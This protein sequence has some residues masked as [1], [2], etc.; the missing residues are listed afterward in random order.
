MPI[1]PADLHSDISA[2]L[3]TACDDGWLLGGSA[4]VWRT[5]KFGPWPDRDDRSRETWVINL[6][7]INQKRN[8]KRSKDLPH[9]ERFDGAWFDFAITTIAD[10]KTPIRLHSYSFEIRF[11]RWP[12]QPPDEQRPHFLRFDLNSPKHD[13]TEIGERCHMHIGSDLFSIPSPW[14]SPIEILDE[15]VYGLRPS[16]IPP[17]G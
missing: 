11:P 3:A 16:N 15:F 6:G 2:L 9:F 14:M 12:G 5:V 13:N 8:T 17:P 4:A 10:M 7:H 1:L